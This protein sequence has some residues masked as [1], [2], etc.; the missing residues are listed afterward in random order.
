M[1]TCVLML[2]KEVCAL[3]SFPPQF[4]CKSKLKVKYNIPGHTIVYMPK[5]C[6]HCT[7]L[8]TILKLF[9]EW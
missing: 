9:H 6:S 3:W 7:S 4:G 8:H 2:A 5:C 1:G